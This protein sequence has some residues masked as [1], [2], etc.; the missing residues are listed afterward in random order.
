MLENT[1]DTLENSL[2]QYSLDKKNYITL[3]TKLENNIQKLIKMYPRIKGDIIHYHPMVNVASD[4]IHRP[5]SIRGF[6]DFFSIDYFNISEKFGFF[7]NHISITINTNYFTKSKYNDYNHFDL[8][9][10]GEHVVLNDTDTNIKIPM[11]KY[12]QYTNMLEKLEKTLNDFIKREI[13]IRN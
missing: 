12:F 13:P 4:D 8:T 1:L 10:H 6:V 11:E 3:K 7:S 5:I 9:G 2:K